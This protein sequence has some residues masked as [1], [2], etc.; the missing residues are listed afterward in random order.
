MANFRADVN[1]FPGCDI[2]GA[3]PLADA[4]RLLERVCQ[5]QHAAVVPACTQS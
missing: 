5:L 4:R 3:Q 1:D 2:G